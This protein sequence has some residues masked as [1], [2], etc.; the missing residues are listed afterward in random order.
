METVTTRQRALV[1]EDNP[2]VRGVQAAALKALDID[3]AFADDGRAGPEAATRAPFFDVVVL[4][5]ALP[6][7]VQGLDILRAL[8][9]QGVGT[10]VIVVS[11]YLDERARREA[12]ATGAF[13]ILDKP[14]DLVELQLWVE[15]ALRDAAAAWR[16]DVRRVG[17]LLIEHG[18]LHVSRAGQV[19]AL[20]RLEFRLLW[21][22][23]KEVGTVVATEDLVAYLWN[24]A[25][26]EARTSLEMTVSRLRRKLDHPGRAS[27]IEAERGVG[28]R[29]VLPSSPPG[30]SANHSAP[31]FVG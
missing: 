3:V 17:D 1:I 25:H 10:P 26:R 16:K 24:D 7:V 23:T 13:A 31:T 15:Q 12:V 18:R 14:F 30:D 28:Y 8:Q 21:R 20:T 27:H 19:V 11:G 5:L 29:F 4:D 9:A 6:G 2:D 22:L